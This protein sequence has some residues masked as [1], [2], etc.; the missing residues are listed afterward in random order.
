MVSSDGGCGSSGAVETGWVVVA[1]PE[2]LRLR[3]SA[4]GVGGTPQ[5]PTGFRVVDVSSLLAGL[6]FDDTPGFSLV[7]SAQAVLRNA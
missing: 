7:C 4:F 3:L 5:R 6:N 2:R 1:G